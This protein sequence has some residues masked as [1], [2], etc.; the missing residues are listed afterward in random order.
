METRR[1]ETL[2]CLQSNPDIA[3]LF[4]NR[5]LSRKVEGGGKPEYHMRGNFYSQTLTGCK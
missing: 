3:P 4:V 2:N 1:P 5:N